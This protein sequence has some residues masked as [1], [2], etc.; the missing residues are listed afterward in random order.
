MQSSDH[1]YKLCVVDSQFSIQTSTSVD[2]GV[3]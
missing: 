2:L 3:I 1:N